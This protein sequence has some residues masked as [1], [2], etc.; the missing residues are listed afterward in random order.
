MER[1]FMKKENRDK[2]YKEIPK[3][4]RKNFKRSNVRN[5]LL[6][7]MYVEDYEEVTG[8]KLT[9]ADKGFGNTV[10]KTHFSVLYILRERRN[11]EIHKR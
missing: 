10:Y 1:L 9:P 5:Q 3:N 8:R 6:H 7:P 4:K 2:A 11:K